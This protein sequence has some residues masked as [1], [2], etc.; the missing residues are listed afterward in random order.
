MNKEL[1][2]QTIHPFKPAYRSSRRIYRNLGLSLAE[3]SLGSE[4]HQ[5]LSI[6][7]RIFLSTLARCFRLRSTRLIAWPTPLALE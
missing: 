5:A 4:L 2:E 7:C 6:C 3:G 1:R